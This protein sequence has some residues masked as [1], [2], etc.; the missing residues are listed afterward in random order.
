ML[1]ESNK[2]LLWSKVMIW[3][4]L[5]AAGWSW[6]H[7]SLP[8]CHTCCFWALAL[9]DPVGPGFLSCWTSRWSSWGVVYCGSVSLWGISPPPVFLSKPAAALA[10]W[11]WVLWSVE[12]YMQLGG[13]ETWLSSRASHLLFHCPSTLLI[14]ISLRDSW[15]RV[16]M[17]AFVL[18]QR[19]CISLLRRPVFSLSSSCRRFTSACLLVNI[20]SWFVVW[21][22]APEKR[23][24]V[25]FKLY[26]KDLILKRYNTLLW[27]ILSG[28]LMASWGFIWLALV[29]RA[30]ADR[31][32][33]AQ[34]ACMVYVNKMIFLISSCQAVF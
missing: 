32:N 21:Y 7:G 33:V 24:T 18:A 17:W 15:C 11:G 9:P 25:L 23:K 10:V 31:L 13:V 8:E 14:W 1:L 27:L 5:P 12:A 2:R 16:S 20:C 22:W 6:I 4:S 26:R 19:F 30:P 3:G 34:G 29:S 28:K